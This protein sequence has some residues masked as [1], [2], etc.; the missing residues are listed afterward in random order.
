MDKIEDRTP[1]AM[2]LAAGKGTRLGE[3][4]GDL[5]K[6]LMPVGDSTMLKLV[7]ERLQEVGVRNLAINT[8]HLAEQVE[9]YVKSHGD[10]GMEVY[11]SV[12]A[13]LLDTGGG[14]K[15]VSDFLADAEEII[16]HNADIYSEFSLEAMLAHH[17]QENALATLAVR[18]VE[19]PRVLL[20][21]EK[22]E[23]CGWENRDTEVKKLARTV[24]QT[25]ALG[26]CGIHVISP[27][28]FAFMQEEEKSSII[29]TYLHAAEQGERIVPFL[30]G[31]SY[32]VDVGTPDQLERLR[33]H[34]SE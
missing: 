25:T 27:R 22:N 8:H 26:F 6:C 23:F 34:L 1:K 7:V 20:F 33:D 12:E 16:V 15:R 32:W 9:E 14:L 19:E 18:Q 24:E 3:L 5:P 30:L 29:T 31:D 10:F 17:R 2:I 13:E 28:L 21:D 11:I 4:T